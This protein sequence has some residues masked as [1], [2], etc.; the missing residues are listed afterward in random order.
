MK[1]MKTYIGVSTG[2]YMGRDDGYPEL[3]HQ[4]FDLLDVLDRE[5]FASSFNQEAGEHYYLLEEI[6]LEDVVRKVN[7]AM[8]M[9]RLEAKLK[10]QAEKEAEKEELLARLKQ[11]EEE[12]Y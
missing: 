5:R 4:F 8:E 6:A 2:S 12:G 10:E 3:K 7:S 11:L 9:I 1:I